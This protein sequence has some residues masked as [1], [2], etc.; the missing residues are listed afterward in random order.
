MLFEAFCFC[1]LS[2]SLFF[3]SHSM[4]LHTTPTCFIFSTAKMTTYDCT[5]ECVCVCMRI[6]N[7]RLV[8]SSPFSLDGILLLGQLCTWLSS[9]MAFTV[10]FSVLS[11]GATKIQTFARS[12]WDWT[13]STALCCSGKQMSVYVRGY[14]GFGFGFFFAPKRCVSSAHN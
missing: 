5:N 1:F 9:T 8:S 3:S 6:L 7:A 2:R 4:I 12:I 10:A 11:L 14:F 13:I